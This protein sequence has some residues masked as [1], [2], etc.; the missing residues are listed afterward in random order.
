MAKRFTATEKWTDPW[1]RK[2]PV[3][4]KAL[5]F[6]LLEQCDHAGVWKFDSGAFGYFIGKDF[7]KEDIF[8]TFNEGKE[9]VVSLNC[10]S[11]WFIKDFVTFQYGELSEGSRVHNSVITMLKKEGVYKGYTKGVL[12]LT[13][14]DM[15]MVKDK[16]KDIVAVTGEEIPQFQF[17]D[18]WSKYPN[19]DGRKMALRS[20][21]VTVKTEKDWIDINKALENYIKS[22]KVQ[23]GFI[24]NGS[25][26]FN[27]WQDWVSYEEPA[28]KDGNT[29]RVKNLVQMVKGGRNA[30][31]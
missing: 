19:K 12:R 9:R 17:E 18:I 13:D 27:N 22:E 15:D 8:K 6:F 23:K 21:Q 16:D 20:F 3:D 5:W 1:F 29:D 4:Y 31:R 10:G 24:K 28:P 2:L 11:K 30:S 25:T 7:E 14:M 26:W